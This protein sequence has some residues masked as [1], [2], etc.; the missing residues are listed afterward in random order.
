MVPFRELRN[1][2]FDNKFIMIYLYVYV[3][4]Y[5]YLDLILSDIIMF[6]DRLCVSYFNEHL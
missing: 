2:V 4:V 5:C 6:R 3:V 1:F